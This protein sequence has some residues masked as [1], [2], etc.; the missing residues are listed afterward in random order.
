MYTVHQVAAL[1]GATVKALHHYDKI[2]LL[3]PATRSEAGY[4]LYGEEDL[5]RLQEILF[6]KALDFSLTDIQKMLS[7]PHQ[8]LSNLTQQRQ[9]L[10]EKIRHLQTLIAS[11]DETISVES[12][13]EKMTEN[14]L[15]KGFKTVSEWNHALQAQNDYLQK[16]YQTQVKVTDSDRQN[17]LA[18]E[19]QS[20]T[21]QVIT[22]CRADRNPSELTEIV[23][24]HLDFQKAYQLPHTADSFVKQT[25][26]FLSDDFHHKML[27]DQQ[28]GLVCYLCEVAKA[29]QKQENS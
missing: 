28:A 6:Y 29:Y 15:F 9:L 14:A 3:V 25:A 26:F 17:R 5:R 24:A 1:S 20:F 23:R 2:G 12:K 7:A 22:A 13:G 21:Q 16:T 19:A 18:K 8:R 10:T 27:E 4:R 11:L